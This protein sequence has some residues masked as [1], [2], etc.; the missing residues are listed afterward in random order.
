MLDA[1]YP[2]LSRDPAHQQ[3]ARHPDHNNAAGVNSDGATFS[4]G[5]EE[6]R[7]YFTTQP[8]F[9]KESFDD[10]SDEVEDNHAFREYSDYTNLD[11]SE[12]AE[13]EHQL[14]A[15]LRSNL[16]NSDF[17]SDFFTRMNIE[18][19]VFSIPGH[20]RKYLEEP[21]EWINKDYW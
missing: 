7:K 10:I 4:N 16:P 15:E 18:Q 12:T 9:V 3:L 1:R 6:N 11:K 14:A 20:F 21:P 13:P 5:N 19:M 2:V 8:T 17:K